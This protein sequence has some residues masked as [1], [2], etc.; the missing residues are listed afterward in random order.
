[1]SFNIRFLIFLLIPLMM[2]GQSGPEFSPGRPG[3]T[4]TSSVIQKGLF[5]FEAG[6]SKAKGKSGNLLF[7]TGVGDGLEIR[8]ALEHSFKNNV[9][10]QQLTGGSLFRIITQDGLI[11]QFAILTT[12]TF[13]DLNEVSFETGECMIIGAF[14]YSL[15][16]D[17]SFDWNLGTALYGSN[18]IP[19]EAIYTSAIGYGL[20]DKLGI[21]V[22]LYGASHVSELNRTTPAFDYGITYLLLDGIQVDL[23]SGYGI[24]LNSEDRFLDIGITFRVPQ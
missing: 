4:E 2:E 1:M 15:T 20:S 7:R 11:P 5:Q 22:E 14:S 18:N 10:A 12:F 16:E 23:S 17:L 9:S 8:L 21:F 19:T 3:M 13:P 24:S 6:L